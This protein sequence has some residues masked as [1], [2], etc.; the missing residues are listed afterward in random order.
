M[1]KGI[2]GVAQTGK[3]L[4]KILSGGIQAAGV[5]LVPLAI[6]KLIKSRNPGMSNA[7]VY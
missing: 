5:G 7:G 3:G 4:G 1:W 6:Y 2:G